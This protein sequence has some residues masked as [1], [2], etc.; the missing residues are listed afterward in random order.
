MLGLEG[1]LLV[2]LNSK[3]ELDVKLEDAL[4]EI[5]PRFWGKEV[6]PYTVLLAIFC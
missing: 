4:L 2:R 3:G 1:D 6:S 5:E